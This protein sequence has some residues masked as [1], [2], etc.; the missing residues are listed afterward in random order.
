M[1]RIHNEVV[2]RLERMPSSQE[3]SAAKKKKKKKKPG[4]FPSDW[5][6]NA[7][8]RNDDDDDDVIT[9]IGYQYPTVLMWAGGTRHRRLLRTWESPMQCDAL[10]T[11]ETFCSKA[12][13]RS[14]RTHLQYNVVKVADLTDVTYSKYLS[15]D[16]DNIAWN[17][18]VKIAHENNIAG[19]LE[20]KK[21]Q[22]NSI[23]LNLPVEHPQKH[24]TETRAIRCSTR[25]KK[26]NKN[27]LREKVVLRKSF[28]KLRW[29]CCTV[30]TD[31]FRL[32]RR[33]FARV[34]VTFVCFA[35][36]LAKFIVGF[37]CDWSSIQT[38]PVQWPPLH[39]Y[40]IYNAPWRGLLQ[41]G[42]R[43]L[44]GR[45]LW[46]FSL[47]TCLCQNDELIWTSPW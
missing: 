3:H 19:I 1:V 20:G 2:Q 37:C 5:M 7:L 40:F 10:K 12:R 8:N 27:T 23:S 31:Y 17:L 21:K 15:Y 44:S 4:C 29:F 32:A 36:W 35:L 18:Q 41:P 6:V 25:P 39:D 38:C 13:V 45:V 30:H 16:V 34:P 28:H 22:R 14:L 46:V 47:D 43:M 42:C 26:R 11:E 33:R 9:V 24:N